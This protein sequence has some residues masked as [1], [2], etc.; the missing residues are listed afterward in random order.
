M[1]V[2]VNAGILIS[3][4]DIFSTHL[5]ADVIAMLLTYGL[6]LANTKSI[7]IFQIYIYI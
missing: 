4:R 5:S 2:N 1:L 6:K 3:E 7:I